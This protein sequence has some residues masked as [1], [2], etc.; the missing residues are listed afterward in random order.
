MKPDISN[1]DAVYPYGSRVY[2]TH[3]EF[4]DYDFI[5]IKSGIK[6]TQIEVGKTDI[7]V[8]GP[9]EFQEQLNQHEIFALECF[10]LNEDEILK[11]P[12]RN[13][14]FELSLSLLRS[15]ISE[16]ASHAWVKAKKKFVSPYSFTEDELIRG[17]KSLFHSFRILNFGIQIAKNGRINNYHAAN[18][19]YYE[20]MKELSTDWDIYHEK[21]KPRFNQLATEFKKLA[22]KG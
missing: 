10:F 18:E 13:F 21:W 22:P 15:S 4:S 5:A 14:D 11:K 17:K 3:H 1:Y 8:F 2:G 16:A 12:K 9:Q 7:K 20:I 19:C 6:F